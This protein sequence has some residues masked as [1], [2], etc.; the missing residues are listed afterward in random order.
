VGECTDDCPLFNQEPHRTLG[1]MQ[2]Q[3]TTDAAVSCAHSF[4]HVASSVASPTLPGHTLIAPAPP[5]TSS[6]CL[7]L[8]SSVMDTIS[9]AAKKSPTRAP[10]PPKKESRLPRPKAT[11]SE[12]SSSTNKPKAGN[13]PKKP[14]RTVLPGIERVADLFEGA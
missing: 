6:S 12:P 10:P 1:A 3:A 8:Q 13:S 11:R 5:K 9:Q 7:S 2:D 4:D 14:K